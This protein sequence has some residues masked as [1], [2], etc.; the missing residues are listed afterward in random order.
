MKGQ[1]DFTIESR[2]RHSTCSIRT[3]YSLYPRNALKAYKDNARTSANVARFAAKDAAESSQ[4]K[5]F[6]RFPVEVKETHDRL[7]CFSCFFS[8]ERA[9]QISERVNCSR[10]NKDVL[11]EECRA[12]R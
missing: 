7:N 11:Q 5:H 2:S 12:C 1:M 3:I 6:P 10:S 4:R 8:A 9:V